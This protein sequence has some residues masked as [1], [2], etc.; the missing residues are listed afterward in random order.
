M[1]ILQFL[2]KQIHVANVSFVGGIAMRL[3]HFLRYVLPSRTFRISWNVY[4]L[5][6][7]PQTT[8][9]LFS[10]RAAN[11]ELVFCDV[12]GTVRTTATASQ[13]LFIVQK[14]V[15]TSSFHTTFSFHR[16]SKAK[17]VRCRTTLQ[18]PT[19]LTRLTVEQDQS[20]SAKMIYDHFKYY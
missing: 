17:H 7:N 8:T 3:W 4:V 18:Q 16:M 20:L 12:H 6:K 11:D 2:Y 15:A 19:F 10:G 5:Y 9:T 1:H 13:H 14:K